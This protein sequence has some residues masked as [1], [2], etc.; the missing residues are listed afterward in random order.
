M[1]FN[2]MKSSYMNM[3]V[4]QPLVSRPSPSCSPPCCPVSVCEHISD[5]FL[6]VLEALIDFALEGL[7]FLLGE[8]LSHSLYFCFIRP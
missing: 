3:L 4:I 8:G 1:N 6:E 5:S 7:S 2:Q